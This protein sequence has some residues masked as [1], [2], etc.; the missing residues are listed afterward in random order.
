M[1]G[2]SHWR[3]MAGSLLAM[4]A[5][6][7]AAIEAAPPTPPAVAVP[8]A[9]AEPLDFSRYQ[10]ILDRQPFGEVAPVEAGGDAAAAPSAEAVLKDYEL[11]AIIEDG[12]KLQAGILDKR[13]SKHVYL[14]A[15]ESLDGMQL[16]SLDYD[17]EQ[18]VLQR[19]AETVVL[20]LRPA[21]EGEA[22]AGEP[23]PAPPAFSAAQRA[24]GEPAIVPFGPAAAAGA[25]GRRPFFGDAPG[26][27][28]FSPFQPIGT[29]TPFQ[30]RS[31]ESFFKPVTN[32]GGATFFS[33][34]RPPAPGT[35]GSPPAFPF[36]PPV[37]D[38][39]GGDAAPPLAPPVPE[40][41]E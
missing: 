19:D 13:T 22:A 36:A 28:P 41:A 34:F 16:V 20:K 31:L 9:A 11:K 30:A 33:P 39:G 2:A 15:G 17:T 21:Q 24:P 14:A 25:P 6:A 27:R 5:A 23:P 26:R 18:A 37:A 38:T 12:G 32:E 35:A 7:A 4:A 29:G 1:S 40:P 10:P 3:P 8:T